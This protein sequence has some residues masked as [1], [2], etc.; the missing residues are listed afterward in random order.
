MGFQFFVAFGDAA[1]INV[2]HFHFL[3]QEKEQF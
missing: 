1:V 2:E 3:L